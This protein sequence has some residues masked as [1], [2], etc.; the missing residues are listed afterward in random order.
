MIIDGQVGF[1]IYET[2]MIGLTLIRFRLDNENN[3]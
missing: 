1:L 3:Y 2:L